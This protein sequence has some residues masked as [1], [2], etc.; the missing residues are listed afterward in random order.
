MATKAK[1]L[2]LDLRTWGGQ[3]K[4]AGRKPK[5]ARAGVPH[6]SRPKLAARHPVHATLRVLPHVWNLRSRRCFSAIA[7][8]FAGGRERDGFRLIQF[9]VQG[10]HLHLVV[11]ARDAE[12]LSRGMQGLTIRMAK[13]LNRVMGRRGPVF[14][15]RYHEHVL[16]SPS[17]VVRALAYVLGNFAVHARRR[18]DGSVDAEVD[19]YCSVSVE[20]RLGPGPPLVSEP[21]TWLL[22]TGWSQGCVTRRRAS[23]HAWC[24][25]KDDKKHAVRAS[26][27]QRV[28]VPSR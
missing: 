25:L 11:E 7:A 23:L 18:G 13:R 10:N 27:N 3:R 28:K 22:C 12:S 26:P 24:V 1:Q 8:A 4:R 20:V 9:S 5:G 15:D 14:A 19:S 2:K 6:A 21:R 16:R 17:E